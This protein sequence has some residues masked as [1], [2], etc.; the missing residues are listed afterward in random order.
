MTDFLADLEG[1][2]LVHQVSQPSH[3]GWPTLAQRL[4]QG[5]LTAYIGF[6][7]TAASL[8]VGSLLPVT[9]LV[10]LQR[11][12]HRP[13]AIV[14]GGTG[15]IG[16]PSGKAT[17]RAMLT[18]D[19]L[20]AN[21]AGMRAQ[22]ER[23]VDFAGERGALLV[24]N[25]DWLCELRLVDFLRDIG[26][27]F[28]VNQMVVRDSVKQ[29]LEGREHGISYTEFSYSLLQGY[30]F[31]VLH[32]RFGCEL[33]MGGSD[34]W[35]NITDGIDLIRRLRGKPAYGL[36]S[37]LVTKSDGSKFGKS[38]QGNVWL[39]AGLTRPFS[40]HQFWLNQSDADAVRYLGYFTFLPVEELAAIAAEMQ[41]APQQRAAQKRLADEVTRFVHGEAALAS[42]RRA[43]AVLFEG[44]DLRALSADELAD[45]FAEAPR[46]KL[47]AATLG[48]PDASLAAVL[49]L[50]KLEPSRGRARTAIESGAVSVNGVVEKDPAR[51]LTAADRLTGGFVVLRRGKKSYHVVETE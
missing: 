50:T 7:P 26:K 10:R 21:V 1:R 18:R 45:A 17:E 48:T 32:D 12:G 40:F 30:D 13:I 34:Q 2:G 46:T 44:G 51:V 42:A 6:D 38:E 5:P 19:Q 43:G 9:N 35:G 28:S 20:E 27:L 14:G 47:G 16:D 4:A 39:D 24:N 11:A 36:T 25:A 31:L 49:A 29:R 41:A 22:L 8:H 15:L 33:Q 23:F 37:P 3:E